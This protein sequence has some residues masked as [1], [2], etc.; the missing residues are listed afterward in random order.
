MIVATFPG[1]ER[2]AAIGSWTAW[3]GI[4]SVVGP[5]AGGYLV[6]AV[7]WRLIFAVNVP[8]VADHARAGLR[9]GSRTRAPDSARSR[10]LARS[11]AHLLRP[12]RSRA[13]A[14]PS[15]G[16]WLGQPRRCGSGAWGLALLGAFVVHERRTPEPMLPLGLFT[17]RNFAVGKCGDVRDVRRARRHVLSARPLSPGGRRLPRAAGGPRVDA[18]DDRACSRSPSEWAASRT[19]SVRVCSW[20]SARWWP[21][22]VWC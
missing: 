12:G 9:C 14:D 5:V 16:G 18:V 8:F 7:S 10:G 6:D 4:A 19:G 20:D 1:D 11:R 13:G 22:P 2:G 3:A 17:R 15:A 21:P